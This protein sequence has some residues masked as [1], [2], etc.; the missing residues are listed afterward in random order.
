MFIEYMLKTAEG[1]ETCSQN[2]GRVWIFTS[3][4]QNKQLIKHSLLENE[5][6]YVVI[7]NQALPKF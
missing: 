6:R 4:I 1:F 3:G 2:E 5:S 7:Y